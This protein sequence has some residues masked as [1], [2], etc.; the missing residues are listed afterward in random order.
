MS[1]SYLNKTELGLTINKYSLSLSLSRRI[2]IRHITSFSFFTPLFTAYYI[3]ILRSNVKASIFVKIPN[4][5]L[6]QNSRVFYFLFFL[7]Y[8]RLNSTCPLLRS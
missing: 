4:T 8:V 7:V 3:Q 2:F 5:Q 1:S 6:Q